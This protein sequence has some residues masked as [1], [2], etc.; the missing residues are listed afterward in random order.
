M[1]TDAPDDDADRRWSEAGA[2]LG[3]FPDETVLQLTRR[4]TKTWVLFA[5]TLLTLTALGALAG[6]LIADQQG[7]HPATGSSGN[8]SWVGALSLTC[9]VLGLSAIALGFVQMRRAGQLGGRWR[10]QRQS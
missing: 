2:L 6:I 10:A 3:G 4:R 5:A 1:T 8:P 9:T 7:S